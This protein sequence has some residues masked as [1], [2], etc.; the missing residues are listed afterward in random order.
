[1]LVLGVDPGLGGALCAFYGADEGG[2]EMV[3]DVIDMPLI[4]DGKTKKGNV[5][6]QVDPVPIIRFARRFNAGLAYVENVQPMR[7]RKR[8]ADAEEGKSTPTMGAQAFRLGMAVGAVRSAL[9]GLGIEVRL[10]TSGVWKNIFELSADKEEARQLAI[11]LYP[12]IAHL[13]KRK[14]DENRAESILI[15]AGGHRRDFPGS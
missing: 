15:A 12:D 9:M 3:A 2:D 13:L 11:A 5:R 8:G 10:I 7:W 4:P 6:Y 1:M 14:S